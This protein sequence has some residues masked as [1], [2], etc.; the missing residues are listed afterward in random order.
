MSSFASG[1]GQTL[2][3]L[4]RLAQRAGEGEAFNTKFAQEQQLVQQ[5]QRRQQ[6]D[7][8]ARQADEDRQIRLQQLALQNESQRIQQAQAAAREQANAQRQEAEANTQDRQ[9]DIANQFKNRELDRM[10]AELGLKQ[11]REGRLTEQAGAQALPPAVGSPEFNKQQ[12]FLVD[13]LADIA[14]I[15][16]PIE[17]PDLD[18]ETRISMENRRDQINQSL[19]D[20]QETAKTAALNAS[21]TAQARQT[22]RAV[23]QKEAGPILEQTLEAAGQSRVLEVPTNTE[24]GKPDLAKLQVGKIYQTTR[25]PAVRLPGGKWELID[26]IGDIN[27]TLSAQ[28]S[29]PAAS[30]Q[31]SGFLGRG[32]SVG[33]F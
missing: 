23:T 32:P 15:L 9:R 14:K 12:R 10:E 22:T 3:N 28:P 31:P 20:L 1:Q 19:V 18:D 16:D 4:A 26:E 25:G 6:M 17:G 7:A 29:Q 27:T 24:T 30:T 13:E 33:A 5:A 11:Q 21:R 2:T 8:Q